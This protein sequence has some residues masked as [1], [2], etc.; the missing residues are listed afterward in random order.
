MSIKKMILVLSII[1]LSF[2]SVLA[3]QQE[4]KV[5]EVCYDS[6]RDRLWFQ[7]SS[8]G[9]TRHYIRSSEVGR[10]DFNR[11]YA[12]L[13]TAKVNGNVIVFD[14]SEVSRWIVLKD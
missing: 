10:E 12:M 3:V 11:F 5:K 7:C 13:I 1:V 2:S 6:G 8:T 4:G 14:D 9:T